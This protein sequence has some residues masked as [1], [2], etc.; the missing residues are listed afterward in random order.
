VI[1]T[2]TEKTGERLAVA[3]SEERLEAIAFGPIGEITFSSGL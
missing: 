1:R 3:A 2:N